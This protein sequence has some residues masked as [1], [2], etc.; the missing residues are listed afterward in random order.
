MSLL[1]ML[2]KGML[3]LGVH[4][5]AG[6]LAMPVVGHGQLQGP[7]G[8]EWNQCEMGQEKLDIARVK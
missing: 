4:G 6:Q 3:V 5:V 2:Y 7:E 8:G 1:C